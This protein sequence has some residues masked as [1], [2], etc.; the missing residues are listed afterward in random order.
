MK[1]GIGQAVT[2]IEDDRLLTGRGCY[3]D[4]LDLPA[5]C[6]WCWCD[7]RIRMRECGRSTSSR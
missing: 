1:F 7:R 2:R 6:T 3:A 5:R 4:D